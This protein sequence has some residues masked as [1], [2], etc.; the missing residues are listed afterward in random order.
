MAEST[1]AR[2]S[3][4]GGLAALPVVY[5][6]ASATPALASS[7]ARPGSLTTA[8]AADLVHRDPEGVHRRLV[9]ARPR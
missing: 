1:P 8:A 7:A 6:V 9:R 5:T 2:R 3:V 4:L